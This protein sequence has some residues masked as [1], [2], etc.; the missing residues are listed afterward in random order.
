[1]QQTEKQTGFT[2]IE[3]MITLF[4]LAILLTIAVP[5]F[6]A[7]IKNNRIDA[8]TRNLT[9]AFQ[10]ARSEAVSRQTVITVNSG[11]DWSNGLTIYTDTSPLGNTDYTAA[12]DSLIKSLDY[13]MDG[14]TA[15]GNDGNASNLISFTSTGL[16]NEGLVGNETRVIA[17]CDDRDAAEGTLITLSRVGRATISSPPINCAP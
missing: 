13:S 6:T 12:E 1:M 16:L 9:G 2:L 15:N 17:I 7:W 14:I 5:N 8:A 3:L 11:G 4:V 10:L